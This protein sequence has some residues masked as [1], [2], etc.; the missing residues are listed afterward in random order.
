[1]SCGEDDPAVLDLL[2]HDPGGE[3]R[4]RGDADDLRDGVGGALGLAA[5]QLPLIGMRR[6]QPQRVGELRLRRVDAADEDVEDEVAQL[7]VVK[8]VVAVVR[9]DQDRQQ[10]VARVR[11]AWR[12]SATSR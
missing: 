1:M 12:R 9:G 4:H 2:Q 8:A 3:G 10:V 6:E 7:V 5:E 11:R